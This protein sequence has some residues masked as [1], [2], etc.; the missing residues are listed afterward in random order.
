MRVITS[1]DFKAMRFEKDVVEFSI[2]QLQ[3]ETQDIENI[4]EVIVTQLVELPQN[5]AIVNREKELINR[6]MNSGFWL[7]TPEDKLQLLIHKVAP[8]MRYRQQFNGSRGQQNLNLTDVTYKK[9]MV[10]FGPDREMVSVTRYKEMVE[11]MIQNLSQQH[12]IL[13]KIK[14]GEPISES[15]VLQLSQIMQ[16][17]DPFVTE[18]LLQRVYSNQHAT[19]L[20]FIRHILQIEQLHSYE[21]TV[22]S[23]FEQFIKTHTRL[24]NNQIEFMN[25]LKRYL[26]DK[27]H[28][29]KKDLI[30]S[31]FTQMHPQGILGLFA[32]KEIDEIIAVIQTLAA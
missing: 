19:F 32:P 22:T 12:P 14:G 31:P 1:V 17:K 23:A 11:E 8:L 4:K 15:D 28:I 25:M 6:A 24:T 3:N 26:I 27:G 10:E 30:Q 5:I 7:N 13:Q 21:E 16:A 18:K 29:E 9:E 20:Q 2:A